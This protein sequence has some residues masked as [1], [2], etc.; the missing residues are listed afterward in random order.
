MGFSTIHKPVTPLC[1]AFDIDGTLYPDAALRARLIPFTLGNLGFIIALGRARAELHDQAASGKRDASTPR[2]LAGFRRLQAE[3]TGRMWGRPAALALEKAEETVYGKLD[4]YFE[5]LSLFPG[6][7]DCLARLSGAGVRLAALSD[8]PVKRKLAL[9]G[10]DSAFEVAR[11]SEE[12]GLLKPAPEPFLAMAAE[13]GI[14][15]SRIVYVGN[16][17]RYDVAGAK[18]AGM[19][20]ALKVPRGGLHHR[21]KAVPDIVFSDYRDLASSI[22]S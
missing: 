6:V 18:A 15:P 5:G 12:Y 16:S 10:L 1:V 11:C 13:L 2:D 3:V 17:L 4:G 22:L 8:F 9:L 21:G 7:R 20:A 19:T 14:E